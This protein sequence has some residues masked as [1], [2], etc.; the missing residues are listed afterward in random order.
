MRGLLAIFAGVVAGFTVGALL[1]RLY[2]V[3]TAV[4]L[5]VVLLAPAALGAYISFRHTQRRDAR[6]AAEN[7]CNTCLQCGY[8]LR[9]T[10]SRCPEC[11]QFIPLPL[12]QR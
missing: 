8:D 2:I 7:T 10:E 11:G 1:A 4:E 6:D 12:E 5:A 9:A 3:E